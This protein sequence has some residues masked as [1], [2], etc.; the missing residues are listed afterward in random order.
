MLATFN[1]SVPVALVILIGYVL[2]RYKAVG[3]EIWSAVEHI[4]FYV[5]FPFMI[6]RTLANAP[7]SK[8]PIANF[9]LVVFAAAVGVSLALMA[10]RPLL[11]W[12]FKLSGPSFTSVFQGVTRFHGFM[13]LAIIGT[14][15]GQEGLALGAVALTV[16]VPI[17][18]TFSVIVLSL[19]GDGG[20]EAPTA[21][22]IMMRVAQNPL[23]IACFVGLA[24]NATG[25]P[26]VV[27]IA[28][29]QV[30][31]GAMGLAMMAV[32]ASLQLS[33]ASRM[34][35]L[36]GVSVVIRLVGMPLLMIW[37]AWLVGLDGMARTVAI[38]AGAVPTATTSY[39]MAR[40]MGGNAELMANIV[41]FQVLVGA[42]TLPGFI[43]IANHVL[44]AIL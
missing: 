27:S 29:N 32:G 42:V 41:T 9:A 18:N 36:I 14:L 12:L 28:V 22:M 15:Y 5:L 37:L 4:C 34:K 8:L 3:P 25:I 26:G 44:P 43:Y 16:L 19:Y 23:I 21:R 7:L 13:T 1:A 6:V 20:N 40:K 33:E 38:V 31:D 35:F 11:S 24:F 2:R 17:L 30:G 10:I 39:V